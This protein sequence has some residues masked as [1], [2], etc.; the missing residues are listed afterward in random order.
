MNRSHLDLGFGQDAGE[1]SS[2]ALLDELERGHSQRKLVTGTGEPGANILDGTV[3]SVSP[4]AVFV[5]IGR[6]NA[7]ILLLDALKGGQGNIK[8]G[9][10][11]K[12]S[13]GGRDENGFYAL[14]LF[15]I[16]APKDWN[17]LE[18][19]FAEKATITGTVEELIK[20]GLLV[21][22]GARAFLPA[23]R[24]GARDRTEMEKLVGTQIECRITKL[25]ATRESVVVDRRVILQERAAKVKEDSKIQ[26]D[27][28]E[29]GRDQPTPASPPR[30]ALDKP[31]SA[32]VAHSAPPSKYRLLLDKRLLGT[33]TEAEGQQYDTARR[34]FLVQSEA[35]T[36]V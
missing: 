25:N 6:R 33:L 22:I 20:G 4:F 12:V 1:A 16:M 29:I 7:G 17:C 5:D 28:L 35:K 9:D 23:S 31:E 26:I 10:P 8:E 3:V 24:S 19:A 11:I 13:A 2:G 34:S 30:E 18:K 32:G 21:D 36:A 15:K 27:V 14:S